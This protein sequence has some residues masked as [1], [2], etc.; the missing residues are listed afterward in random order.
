MAK[1][2]ELSGID[3]ELHEL[4]G[5]KEISLGCYVRTAKSH[6]NKNKGRIVRFAF[7]PEGRDRKPKDDLAE[8]R[9]GKYFGSIK[10]VNDDGIIEQ[11]DVARW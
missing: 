2:T 1:S 6:S 7:I 3:L 9:A 10:C 4:L 11:L 8:L 5:S